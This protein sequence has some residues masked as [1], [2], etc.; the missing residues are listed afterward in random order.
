[1]KCL[2][3]ALTA[4]I[5]INIHNVCPPLKGVLR[6]G[7]GVPDYMLC[8]ELA[9]SARDHEML[10]WVDCWRKFP[11]S[12]LPVKHISGAQ[13]DEE[14]EGN[15]G[16][17]NYRSGDTLICRKGVV[18]ARGWGCQG[19]EG[20]R[21]QEEQIFS[22]PP[23]NTISLILL[24]VAGITST[25]FSTSSKQTGGLY[26]PA[27]IE[28][29]CGHVPCFGQWNGV[30]VMCVTSWQKH[31]MAGLDFPSWFSPVLPM[32]MYLLIQKCHKIKVINYVRMRK[33][34]NQI[35]HRQK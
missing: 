29:K 10:V 28:V 32:W 9:H 18:T 13:R 20:R 12:G 34:Q 21:E 3:E 7:A 19:K 5:N 23:S 26:F 25:C 24:F 35:K 27:S 8:S 14:K 31:L 4:A 6:W 15:A 16:A 30:E 22:F 33:K 1:M 11:A 2:L 17:R